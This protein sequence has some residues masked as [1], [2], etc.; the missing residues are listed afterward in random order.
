MCPRHHR[1]G[2][3]TCL[4]TFMQIAQRAELRDPDAYWA[5]AAYISS[6]P[7]I[8]EAL[9]FSTTRIHKS[10]CVHQ[11]QTKYSRVAMLLD[12]QNPRKW[13]RTERDEFEIKKCAAL[14]CRW[15]PQPGPVELVGNN[16]LTPFLT[17][18]ARMKRRQRRRRSALPVSSDG[19]A[20]QTPQTPP[21]SRGKGA[22]W[23]LAK[24]QHP[25]AG[26]IPAALFRFAEHEPAGGPVGARP[27]L[28]S[29]ACCVWNG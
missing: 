3:R 28:A 17:R 12:H 21:N 18:Q 15:K 16:A 4:R 11:Q 5:G 1:L 13:I 29:W 23:P 22:A 24:S 20:W 19:R 14:R 6:K 9:C 25:P 2:E 7:N 27:R 26:R 8:L 10:S